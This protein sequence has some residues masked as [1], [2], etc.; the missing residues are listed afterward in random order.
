MENNIQQTSSSSRNQPNTPTPSISNSSSLPPNWI[1]EMTEDGT[2]CYYYNKLTGEMRTNP[3]L[4]QHNAPAPASSSSSS[5]MDSFTYGDMESTIDN[6]DVDDDEF[7]FQSV[8]SRL[9]GLGSR[10]QLNMDND[11]IILEEDEDIIDEDEDEE[12]NQKALL[13]T[14]IHF[15]VFIVYIII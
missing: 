6:D 14:V 10:L 7:D 8:D 9:Q 4:L 11:D 1:V 5:I 13:D 15:F 12:I 2:G 3:P